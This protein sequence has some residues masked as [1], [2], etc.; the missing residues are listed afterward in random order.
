MPIEYQTVL[1]NFLNFN[2]RVFCFQDSFTKETDAITGRLNHRRWRKSNKWSTRLRLCSLRNV[3]VERW[4]YLRHFG[5]WLS[6]IGLNR[7]I[8]SWSGK[9]TQTLIIHG[10]LKKTLTGSWSTGL[11][12]MLSRLILCSR[13]DFVKKGWENSNISVILVPTI[14]PQQSEYLVKWDGH[15]EDENSWEPEERIPRK[16]VKWFENNSFEVEAL[17]DTRRTNGKVR[18]F[19]AFWFVLV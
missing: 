12:I 15:N 17:L 16:L 11:R 1:I 10:S 13:S 5:S 6:K 7:T 3:G 19:Q 9:D 8:T 14:F 4:E 18:I 2:R